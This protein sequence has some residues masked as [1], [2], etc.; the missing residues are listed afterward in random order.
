[1]TGTATR[2]HPGSPQLR[3]PPRVEQSDGGKVEEP[4]A[5]SQR[6][7][8]DGSAWCWR[9]SL[10]FPPSNSRSHGGC[11]VERLNSAPPTGQGRKGGGKRS[12]IERDLG[13]GRRLAARVARGVA[14]R[15]VGRW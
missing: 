15:L 3:S 2:R 5:G 11:G 10:P 8:A 4:K 7:E 9:G 1:M 13:G 14:C 6:R 12:R